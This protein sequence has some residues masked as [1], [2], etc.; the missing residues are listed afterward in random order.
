MA[1]SVLVHASVGYYAQ[2]P[3]G[4]RDTAPPVASETEFVELPPIPQ[5]DPEPSVDPLITP[6]PEPV[7]AVAPT[8]HEAR[9]AV[10][11]RRPA[12]ERR[13]ELTPFAWNSGPFGLR[14][15]LT[16]GHYDP[17]VLPSTPRRAARRDH[18]ST[19]PP[20]E[21][22]A[23]AHLP[24][25]EPEADVVD[26]SPPDAEAETPEH[27]AEQI[28]TA[29]PAV[30]ET[31]GPSR[32]PDVATAV[33]PPTPRPRSATEEVVTLEFAQGAM[34]ESTQGALDAIAEPALREA[35]GVDPATLVSVMR[36]RPRTSR[37]TATAFVTTR[38]A[39]ELRA[40]FEARALARGGEAVFAE[41]DG[42]WTTNFS[43]GGV[44]QT[45][46]IDD[47]VLVVAD[48]GAAEV[49]GHA[50]ARLAARERSRSPDAPL[51]WVSAHFAAQA[52]APGD[53][54]ASLDVKLYAAIDATTPNRLIVVGIPSPAPAEGQPSAEATPWTAQL[55]RELHIPA[56]TLVLDEERVT[57][58][59]R[60]EL[61]LHPRDIALADLVT[62][63]AQ[64]R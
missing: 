54:I 64:R 13:L 38:S 24:L 17:H 41:R 50:V 2:G 49:T 32:T 59:G 26:V 15:Q 21:L 23:D 35:L 46:V 11:V 44:E 9:N 42:T 45:V 43:F 33:A 16:I 53:R 6:P 58:D 61:R 52:L 3:Q 48:F 4:A 62:A 34:G 40:A 47:H 10:R 19:D 29:E 39:A 63:V 36:M 8:P 28:A 55:E 25:P 56:G 18:P 5:A 27:G 12:P 37:S 22:V 51:P 57:T 31:E 20:P 30:S 7:I 1:A 60:I 14:D